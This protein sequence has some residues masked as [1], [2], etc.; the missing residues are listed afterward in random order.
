M[1]EYELYHY[2]V[3]GM[4][5]GV[6]RKRISDAR[7]ARKQ[8]IKDSMA[9]SRRGPNSSRLG[10]GRKAVKAASKAG[11][12]AY[13]KSMYDSASAKEKARIDKQNSDPLT[14]YKAEAK[15]NRRIRR[16]GAAAIITAGAMNKMGKILYSQVKDNA[17][18]K[19]ALVL[20]GLG[21]GSKALETIGKVSMTAGVIRQYSN[22]RTYAANYWKN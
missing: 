10:S 5:W 11:S 2:G 17:N 3:K 19:A 21:Y 14:V 6:R 15:K 7:T 13:K 4:K 16:A 18:P 9:E 12:A 8:A 22:M 20:N 1:S